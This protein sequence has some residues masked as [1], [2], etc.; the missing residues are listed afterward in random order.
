MQTKIQE[1][2]KTPKE[3]AKIRF[4]FFSFFLFYYFLCFA[5]PESAS[6]RNVPGIKEALLLKKETSK[7]TKTKKLLNAE[8]RTERR[9]RFYNTNIK[10]NPVIQ[11]ISNGSSYM[12]I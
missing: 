12:N 3:N 11:R 7:Q 1:N 8:R 9:G 6:N 2:S 4:L 5:H 10:N